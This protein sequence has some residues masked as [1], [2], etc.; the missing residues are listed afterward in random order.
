MN[1]SRAAWTAL[2][3]LAMVVAA[4]IPQSGAAW[5]Q[6]QTAAAA[7]T[8]PHSLALNGTSAYAEVTHAPELNLVA[9]WTIELWFK[10]ESAQGYFHLPRVLLTKGDPLIDR[11]VPYGLAIAFGVLAVGERSGDGGR[12]LAYNLAQ[13]RVSANAWHHVAASLQSSSGTLALYLDGVLVAQRSAPTADRIGNSRSLSIGR[14]GSVGAFWAGKLD[15]VRLWNVARTARQIRAS[16]RQQLGAPETG[17]VANWQFDEGIG[18]LAQDSAG[19]HV[20]SLL[21]GASFSTDVPLLNPLDTP[22]ATPS[23]IPTLTAIP[24]ATPSATATVTATATQTG[25][26]TPTAMPTDTPTPTPTPSPTRAPT[27]TPTPTSTPTET[28]SPTSTPTPTATLTS[29]LTPTPPPTPPPTEVLPPDPSS[30][31][32]PLDQTLATDVFTSTQFLY[33]GPNPIQTG[34]APG[35]IDP[36]RVAVLRGTVKTPDGQP[37][38][39]VTVTVHGRAEFGQTLTRQDGQFDMAANGGAL[40][41]IEYA[42]PGFLKV[43]RQVQAPQRDFVHLPDVTLTREDPRVTTIDLA[44]AQVMQVARG[45][46]VTDADGSRQATVLF[47]SGTSAML[48][49]PDG[50]SRPL[51][52]PHVHVTEYTVGSSG[53]SA[54]PG[55]LP[56][57][58]A[59]TY[60]AEFSV[61]EARA[62]GATEVRFS[63][64]VPVYVE[65]FLNFATGT[66]VPLGTYDTHQG[67]LGPARQRPRDQDREHHRR[68]GGSGHRR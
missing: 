16:Y 55:D 15:D 42:K 48:V 56:P 8:G 28:P 34:V 24:T 2:L 38:P 23:V 45:S 11:Q 53:P 21:G 14:D 6:L 29:M 58:S 62:A 43:Q 3:V 13:H 22:T 10:D 26:A 31:A 68:R 67:P 1:P 7:E 46:R 25:T 18:G 47:P 40:L 19:S 44:S 60:A 17:L 64:P 5:T 27:E 39:G 4:E 61:E 49:F 50:S 12:L 59:Y 33:T 65:N 66:T 52:S 51:T 41:L 30:V 9:D 32:P 63:S 57:T 37:L 35:A 54:M 36:K 20:A